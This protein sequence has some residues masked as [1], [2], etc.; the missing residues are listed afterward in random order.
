MSTDFSGCFGGSSGAGFGWDDMTIYKVG[1]EWNT[2]SDWTWR[3]GYSHGSQ[4]IADSEVLLNILAPAV[5]EDHVAF[6]FTK[7]R[8][9]SN[10][11]NVS[12]MYALEGKVSGPN[13]FDPTQ[14]I[15]IRMHQWELEVSYSWRF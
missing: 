5:I 2:G 9:D 10:E 14:D 15:E 12:F 3:V 1:V 8:H 7:K 4:P 13:P 11:F 6:G